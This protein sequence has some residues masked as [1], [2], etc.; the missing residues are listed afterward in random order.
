MLSIHNGLCRVLS[1]CRLR[2]CRIKPQA[3]SGIGGRARLQPCRADGFASR[4]SAPV[5]S[6]AC[7]AKT[8]DGDARARRAESPG[9]PPRNHFAAKA[10]TFTLA[11]TALL[12][13]AGCR[14]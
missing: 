6:A 8:G 3:Q 11:V 10:A 4:A 14:E 13:L 9:L 2:R 12:L 5:P 1:Q 7:A